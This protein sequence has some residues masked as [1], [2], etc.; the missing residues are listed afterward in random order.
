MAK[1]RKYT[2]APRIRVPNNERALFTVE[3]Q[4]FVGVVVRLSLTGGSAIVSK[5][6]LPHGT[7]GRIGLN[8][9]FGK[10]S[11]EIQFLQG[12]AEGIALAQAFRF[13]GM[14]SVSSR[15]YTAAIE[16]MQKAGFSDAPRGNGSLTSAAG[17]TISKLKYSIQRISSVISS[18]R[19]GRN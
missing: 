3:A 18:N 11:G 2:R 10:V 1:P 16:Q 5:G 6:P 8:T 7:L 17:E 12:G 19:K 4:N 13:I 15:R 9:V 14:D